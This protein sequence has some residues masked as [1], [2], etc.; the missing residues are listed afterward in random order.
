M[1]MSREQMLANRETQHY[2]DFMHSRLVSTV[3]ALMTPF[4]SD[5]HENALVGAPWF[6]NLLRWE[7]RKNLTPIC[8][9]IGVYDLL[10]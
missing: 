4:V 8:W 3:H 10:F 6:D 7:V 1:T 9:W 2:H 5:S